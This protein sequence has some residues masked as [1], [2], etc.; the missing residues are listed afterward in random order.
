MAFRRYA[1]VLTVR[2]AALLA[3]MVLL[4]YVLVSDSPFGAIGILLVLAVIFQTM[5]LLR[6]V[7]RTNL[8][9]TRFLD[10]TRQSDF[11]Q[12]FSLGHLGSDFEELGEAFGTIVERF[13]SNRTAAEE[14]YRYL[15]ALVE[16]VPVALLSIHKDGKVELLN[17]AAR[18]LLGVSHVKGTDDLASFGAA[19]QRD[20]SQAVPGRRKLTKINVDGVDQ[21][22]IMSST[23][24][25]VSSGI[26]NLLALQNIQTELDATE[27]AAWQELVRVITHEIM[28]SITPVASL[29]KTVAD[30]VDDVI[31]DTD[32]AALQEEMRDVKDAVQVLAQRSEGLMHFV[33]SYRQLTQAPPP[34]MKRVSLRE[35][36]SR[37]EKLMRAEWKDSGVEFTVDVSPPGLEIAG[38]AE[39]LD[40][41][42]I[43]LLRNGAD[44]VEGQKD[45]RVWLLARFSDR[46]RTIIE[47]ADNG[48]GVNPD[49]ADRIFVPFFTTKKEGSGIGLS[50][51]RQVAQIHGGAVSLSSREGGGS[52]FSL[53]L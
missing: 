50:L 39:L 13:K 33:Q 49:L 1:L 44:A 36:F 26:Q 7:K 53:V 19:F 8:E 4:A 12:S 3:T 15:R 41:A 23:Q 28:N 10:S 6:Y 30:L 17:N 22:L 24:I 42:L 18:R 29:A 20:I 21:H 38:D 43:N 51:V 48:T 47:V 32:E 11:T 37:L 25:T 5:D 35:I 34:K 16:H 31:G 45:A 2:L 52:R 46:G 40:Q 9:L 27:L 14:Q